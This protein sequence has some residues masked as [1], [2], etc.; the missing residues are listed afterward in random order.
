MED[1]ATAH[2]E[3]VETTKRKS[4]ASPTFDGGSK[5]VRREYDRVYFCTHPG[6][7]AQFTE[8]YKL[9]NHLEAHPGT[10][11]LKVSRMMHSVFFGFCVAFPHLN[12]ALFD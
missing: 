7:T 9:K 4:M 3:V 1:L 10:R 11:P 5:A 12:Y 2:A 8:E 6:C